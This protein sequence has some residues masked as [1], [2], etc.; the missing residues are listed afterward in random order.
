MPKLKEFEEMPIF[1]KIT[2]K[3]KIK[4]DFPNNYKM[5]RKAKRQI[6]F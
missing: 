1:Q 3:K 5:E 4:K 2:H 6:I